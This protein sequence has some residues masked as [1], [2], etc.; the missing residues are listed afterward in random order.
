MTR[1]KRMRF[2][3]LLDLGGEDETGQSIP[4]PPIAPVPEAMC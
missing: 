1:V 2:A 3:D 4:T